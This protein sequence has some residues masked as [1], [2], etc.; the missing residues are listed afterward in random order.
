MFRRIGLHRT[1]TPTLP[2]HPPRRQSR[3][4]A[5]DGAAAAGRFVRRSAMALAAGLLALTA[6]AHSGGTAQAAGPATGTGALTFIPAKGMDISPM[7]VVTSAP[8]PAQAG[9]L[10]GRI[11]GAGFP[12]AGAVV[13]PN[14]DAAVRHDSAF[15]VPLQDTLQSFAQQAGTAL[16]GRYRFVLQC[17]DELATQV[18]A[19]FDGAVVFSDH[20]HFTGNAPKRPPVVGVPIGFLA[21]VFP[22]FKPGA[23]AP[24][25]V[26]SSLNQGPV[27]SAQRAAAA[28]GPASASTT[29][30]GSAASNGGSLTFAAAIV[31]LAGL[32]GAAGFLFTRRRL[33]SDA[34]RH[35][36]A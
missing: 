14:S 34:R 27:Q 29:G 17:T 30:A 19:Q 2:G 28:S 6:V 11:F 18:Y 12:A 4:A 24:G 20:T 9:N 36:S 1:M 7:Y 5:L 15:G 31:L 3:A 26:T 22:E 8:C 16:H 21:Q 23:G 35:S 33:S 13:I 32:L 25:S 10:V